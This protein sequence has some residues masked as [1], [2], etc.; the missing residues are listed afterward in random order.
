MVAH[1][2][3]FFIIAKK[4]TIRPPATTKCYTSWES[5]TA[6]RHC[7]R[8]TWVETAATRG[9]NKAGNL[10]SSSE[11]GYSFVTLGMK[12]IWVWSSGD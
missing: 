3:S 5:L 8:T 7:M 12:I 11:I 6:H 1:T 4:K 2:D 9:M 10:A